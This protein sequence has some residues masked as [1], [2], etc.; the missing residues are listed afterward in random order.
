MF[1]VGDLIS[2]AIGIISHVEFYGGTFYR[3]RGI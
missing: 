3:R 1:L 2:C